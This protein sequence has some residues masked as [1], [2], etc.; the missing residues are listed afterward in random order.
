VPAVQPV[1]LNTHID[2]G[3]CCDKDPEE[4]EK[5]FAFPTSGVFSADGSRFFFSALGSDKVGVVSAGALRAGF[6]HDQARARGELREIFLGDDIAHPSGPVGLALDATRERLY[7]KTLF[8]NQL[9]V[10]DAGQER[11]SGRLGLPSPEPAS[12]TRGRSILYNARLTSSHGDSACASCHIF[13]DL[14]GLS[15]DLGNPD[16]G[17]VKNPGPREWLF[18]SSMTRVK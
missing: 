8:D 7:V 11:I 16:A 13:G 9:V 17:T 15:W 6:D 10:I 14:D 3:R 1:H 12:I 2:Y 5:S 18:R 4:N